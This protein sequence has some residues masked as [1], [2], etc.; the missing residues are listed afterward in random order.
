MVRYQPT[1]RRK[2]GPVDVLDIFVTKHCFGS[3]EASR[4]ASVLQS[5]S[6]LQIKIRTLDESADSTFPEVVATPSY[7]LN[8]SLIFLGNPRLEEL[9]EKIASLNRDKA[10]SRG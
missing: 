7:F 4:L 1:V 8:G 10:D 5:L 3:T 6:G 2:A 9:M